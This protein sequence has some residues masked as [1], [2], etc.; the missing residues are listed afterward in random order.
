MCSE[1]VVF[2][3][4]QPFPD[5]WVPMERLGAVSDPSA[6]GHANALPLPP[7]HAQ[8]VQEW[9]QGSRA[10]DLEGS[11]LLKRAQNEFNMFCIPNR[12]ERLQGDCLWA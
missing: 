5:V 10:A 4:L 11:R 3:L 7:E 6:P 2:A 8:E 9:A 12:M 1:H